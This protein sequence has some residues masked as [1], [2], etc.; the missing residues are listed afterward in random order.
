MNSLNSL[1]SPQ[2]VSPAMGERGTRPLPA[3]AFDA[4]LVLRPLLL[5]RLLLALFAGPI[6]LATIVLQK[7]A[8][9]T[10]DLCLRFEDAWRDAVSHK[11]AG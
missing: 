11:R 8:D 9:L 4:M 1:R 5:R 2:G 7:P 10:A 6:L 3:R